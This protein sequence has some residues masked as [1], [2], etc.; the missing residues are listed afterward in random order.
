MGKE[1]ENIT[2]SNKLDMDNAVALDLGC[3]PGTWLM[4]VATEYPGGQFYGVDLYNIFPHNIRPANVNFKCHDALEGLPYPDNT[5]DLVNMRMLFIALKKNEWPIVYKE[6]Y[7]VLKPGG[8]IQACECNTLETGNEFIINVGKGFRQNM[9][10]RDQDP[11]IGHNLDTILKELDFNILEFEPKKIFFGNPDALSKEFVW[12]IV[13]IMKN[14]QPLLEESMGCNAEQYQ[15]F[16]VNFE[17]ELQK[18]PDAT[19]TY[20]RCIGQK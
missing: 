6:V 11:F 5:F 12:N 16:L 1:E 15:A 7:R 19:W 10:D 9:T 14:T 20:F 8:F 17:Q 2:S 3:G 4:D 13:K 18:K